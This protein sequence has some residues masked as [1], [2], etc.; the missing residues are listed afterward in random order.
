MRYAAFAMIF[1][2]V[3]AAPAAGQSATDLMSCI[4]IARDADRLACYDAA[5]AKVSPQAKALSDQRAKE[6]ARIA[7]AEAAAAEAAAVA[8]AEADAA[9]RAAQ[10]KADFGVEGVASKKSDFRERQAAEDVVKL[11]ATVSEILTNRAGQYVFLLDNGQLWRQVS[12]ESGLNIRAGDAVVVEK[13]TMGGYRITF[14]RIKRWLLVK[15]LR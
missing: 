4:E 9:A 14:T 12:T 15:R 3:A 7:A 2:G 5:V 11:D 8:K 1:A 6:T 10:A 13:S